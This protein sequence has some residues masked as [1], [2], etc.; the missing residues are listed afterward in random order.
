MSLLRMWSGILLLVLAAAPAQAVP[1]NFVTVNG[2][3]WAQ[4]ADFTNLSWNDVS[5]G[6][7]G[8][9]PTAGPC[10]ETTG[11][12]S[13]TFNGFDLT[14]WTW[15]SIDDVGALFNYVTSAYND[16]VDDAVHPG[17][18][19]VAVGAG[20]DTQW[21]T[22]FFDVLGF[23]PTLSDTSFRFVTAVTRNHQP[24][25]LGTSVRAGQLVDITAGAA[26]ADLATTDFFTLE[27]ARNA[28]EGPL[29]FRVAA[30]PTPPTLLLFAGSLAGLAL[31]RRRHRSHAAP[32]GQGDFGTG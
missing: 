12:C 24:P 15:A 11:A 32:A 2:V 21:A 14:G 26:L 18:V 9:D 23:A 27:D 5:A 4:V 30:V 10:D 7:S 17:G 6:T 16:G 28:N 13:G 20:I 29:F 25:G 22:A 3:Q 31:V 8:T 19:S 1:V